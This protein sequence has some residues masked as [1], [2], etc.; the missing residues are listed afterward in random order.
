MIGWAEIIGRL[1]SFAAEK[2]LGRKIDLLLDDRLRAARGFMRFY[3]ALGDL[4]VL[5]KEIIVESRA[6]LDDGEDSTVSKEWFNDVSIA[7]DETSERFLEASDQIVESIEIFDPPLALTVSDLSAHKFSFLVVAAT[8][9]KA[10]DDNGYALETAEYSKPTDQAVEKLDL[11]GRYEWYKAN[12]PLDA[13]KSLEW[14]R[15]AHQ[16]MLDVED[17]DNDFIRIKDPESLRRLIETLDIHVKTLSD[18]REKFAAFF[19]SNFSVED[20]LAIR[21]PIR[22]YDRLHASKR[23]SDA[24]HLPY[25]RYFAGKPTRR[26]RGD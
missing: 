16:S 6:V 15:W 18:A 14:P 10:F 1:A 20:L 9:F 4:E 7:V 3:Q 25:S 8:G 22:Q 5:V 17:V 23:M 11:A 26:A 24:L 13:T 12:Y 21:E 19:R 2:L